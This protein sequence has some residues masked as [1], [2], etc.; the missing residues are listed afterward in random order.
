SIFRVLRGQRDGGD[1][2]TE[3][4]ELVTQPRDVRLFLRRDT[5]QPLP[6]LR[7]I[8][9]LGVLSELRDILDFFEVGVA[10]HLKELL[11]MV[12]MKR[13][14][15]MPPSFLEGFFQLVHIVLWH[16]SVLFSSPSRLWDRY[17][18]ALSGALW[19]HPQET[20]VAAVGQE[21]EQAVRPLPPV[22]DTRPQVADIWRN[23]ATACSARD[24]WV[25]LMTALSRTTA[26]A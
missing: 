2:S 25:Q 11:V 12:W 19:Q 1:F 26:M 4:A 3:R 8:H 5:E 15:E 7:I 18:P 9:A 24:C 14:K 10:K 13:V 23:A 22:A 6:E 20:P 17:H 16:V 21:V